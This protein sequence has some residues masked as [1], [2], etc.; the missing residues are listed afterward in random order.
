M[1]V[2]RAV[3]ER[4]AS[5]H[6]VRV[7]YAVQQYGAVG[8]GVAVLNVGADEHDLRTAQRHHQ[9]RVVRREQLHQQVGRRADRERDHQLEV[10]SAADQHSRRVVVA[11]A[12]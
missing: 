11:F 2:R 4:H 10:N 6:V 5:T 3:G 9:S 1:A 8:V 12:S 7:L